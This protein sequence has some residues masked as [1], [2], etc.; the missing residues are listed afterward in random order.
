MVSLVIPTLSLLQSLYS[1][2][3]FELTTTAIPI[4][5]HSTTILCDEMGGQI[6]YFKKFQLSLS[7]NL[8]SPYI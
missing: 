4:I 1:V 7:V 5:I 3:K 6:A 8:S 2:S